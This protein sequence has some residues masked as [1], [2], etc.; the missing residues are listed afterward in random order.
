VAGGKQDRSSLQKIGPST[1]AFLV[2]FFA[3]GPSAADWEVYI[4][5]GLG[6]SGAIIDTDGL[7]PNP[8]NP[9]IPLTGEDD[10]ASPLLDGA[11]GLRVPMDEIVPREWL[12]NTRLPDWPV[13]LELEAAG[14][15][16]F[17]L[18]TD[19][20]GGT[21]RF[22]TKWKATTF[23]VNVWLDIPFAELWRPVQCLGGLG[24]QP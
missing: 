3:A 16:E 18:T 8:P 21:T 22:F 7:V 2:L 4:S 20:S 19:Q 17:D 15:R 9:G 23:F 5:G 14:L 1:I 13:R 11:V 10:D 24:R 6:I 12:M